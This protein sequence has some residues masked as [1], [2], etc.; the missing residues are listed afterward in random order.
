MKPLRFRLLS[1]LLAT[2]LAGCGNDAPK[3][4]PAPAA[5][6]ME[7]IEYLSTTIGQR[8]AGSDHAAAARDYIQA[9][10]LRLGLLTTLQ[11][12]TF[13]GTGADHSAN[14]IAVKPGVSPQEI[15][16]GAHYDSVD[17][18]SGASDN[19]SGVG[20]LL[21]CAAVLAKVEVPYTIRFVAFGAEEPGML[22]SSYYVSQ[23]TEAEIA[24]T[25]GM[26]N[27][28]TVVGGD[29]IYVYGGLEAAGWLR[30]AALAIARQAGISLDTS[31][32]LNP[33]IP[34]GTTGDWSDHAP[35]KYAGVPYLYLEATNWEIGNFDGFLQTVDH[36]E[37]WHTDKD[38][39]EFFATTYPGR[40]EA[41]L[42][43]FTQ[44]LTGLLLTLEVPQAARSTIS[45]KAQTSVPRFRQR[46]GMPFE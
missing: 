46:N 11:T 21:A 32:G 7:H 20:L 33:E 23:M 9:H 27:L 37:I 36:G 1:I 18:G 29:R 34:A 10:F 13:G 44:I 28:D 4:D 17:V 35:F 45:T 40:I 8:L 43:D 31:P 41:Q 42:G 15:L 30:E 14:V 12:F 24:H 5:A 39:L 25:V 3:Q 26:V 16:V 6:A 2:L 22:G 19:A 38:T